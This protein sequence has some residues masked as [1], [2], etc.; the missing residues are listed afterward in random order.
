MSV[1]IRELTL[2]LAKLGHTLD[3]YTRSQDSFTPQIVDLAPKVRLIHIQAGEQ[4]DLD[5]LLIYSHVPDFACK[6][7]N[8]RKLNNLQYDLI[9][10]HYWLSGIA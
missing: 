9:F 4:S 6:T 1:Y 8:F 3:I 10:S 5:K 7:E 2:E